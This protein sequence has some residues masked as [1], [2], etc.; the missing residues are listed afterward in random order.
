MLMDPKATVSVIVPTFNRASFLRGAV[1]SLLSQ[2]DPPIEVIVVDDG[3]TD[4]T[5]AVVREFGKDIVY[6]RKQN[7]GKASAINLALP[8]ARGEFLWFFDDDDV[9]L[10]DAIERRI[11]AL[12][13]RRELRWIFSSYYFGTTGPDGKIVRGPQKA[14][15]ALPESTLF[16]R[17]L[18]SCFFPLQSCLIHRDCITQIGNFNETLLRSQDY[19]LLLRLAHRF[20]FSGVDEPTFILRMHDGMRG[21]LSDRHST[22]SRARVWCKYDRIIGRQIRERIS[23]VDFTRT[24]WVAAGAGPWDRRLA[25]IQRAAVMAS[26]GLIPEMI[27]DCVAAASESPEPLRNQERILCEQLLRLPYFNIAYADARRVFWRGV[28][29][30]S[31][32]RVGREILMLF[33]IALT[34]QAAY[35]DKR[36]AQRARHL[37]M[38]LGVLARYF[39]VA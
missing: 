24:P 34:S 38:S 9:A 12:K 36:L 25:L 28:R 3:S 4:D 33:V 17:L 11:D 18:L 35:H 32:S 27:E 20:A 16:Q 6:L 19:D 31:K 5:G 15:R 7:G 8:R 30:L 23:L 39:L 21:P 2:T 14:I 13:A 10:P 29:S 37:W 22:S 26:K 1:T